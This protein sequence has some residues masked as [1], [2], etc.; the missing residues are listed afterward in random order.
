[1]GALLDAAPSETFPA[2]IAMALLLI[3]LFHH[4]TLG[5]QVMIEDCVHSAMKFPALIAIRF[6][7]IALAA[8]WILATVRIALG[9]RGRCPDPPRKDHMT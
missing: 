5:V 3:A 8:A 6:A 2:D 1:M 9:N 7:C 4:M